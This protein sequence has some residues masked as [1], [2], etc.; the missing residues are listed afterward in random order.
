[1]IK[2][3]NSL[4]GKK[5]EFVPLKSGHVTMYVCGPTVYGPTHVGNARPAVVFDVVRRYLEYSGFKVTYVSNFTDVD[6][7]IINQSRT[8]KIPAAQIAQ[9]YTLQYIKDMSALR[10]RPP[11]IA[12]KVTDHVPQI[13]AFIKGL[14]DKGAAYVVNDGEVF[15]SIRKFK[16]YGKL[17]KK[18]IDDLRVGVRIQPGELKQDPLDFS[19][20]KPQKAP[21]EPAWESPWGKGRPG[22]H[23]ECSA[24]AMH[25]LGET[26][27]IHGGGLDLLHPHH[28][29]EIAQS[30][31]FS[32]KPFV[33]YW[34]HNNL[35][36]IDNEKMSK[37]LGNM[38][39]NFDFIDKYTAET[40]K[41]VLLSGHYRSP[42]DFSV[43]H[44]RDSQAALHRLY[45]TLNKCV[46]LQSAP[47]S[48]SGQPTAEEKEL[49]EMGQGFAAR[50]R[51]AMDDDLNT[52]KVIGCLFDYVRKLNGYLDRKGFRLTAS[53]QQI[54]GQF[55]ECRKLVSGILNVFG[56]EAQGY[57]AL[58]RE[59]VL[60]DRGLE[61][62]AIAQKIAE[63]TEA[64]QQK[65]FARAD[66][67]RQ[68]LLSLGI[69]VMDGPTGT[70]WDIAF[71]EKS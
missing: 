69:Q 68:E 6:D 5:E 18:R 67:I 4:T 48:L 24:M 44:I 63:R 50:F 70:E 45:T 66:A 26:L 49:L 14:V 55:I 28:E 58:L 29:N 34:L 38:F 22:W 2:L 11:N 33:R 53:G 40:L 30:E 8:E 39:Y 42:I 32:G 9:K 64:R 43:Q 10:V 62:A 17:S 36:N 1:M 12:P 35:L 56:E 21:D 13:I 57:L 3:T 46:S 23:I 52:A 65:D 27:D 7:K 61:M 47:S 54:T 20:W 19:L 15:F 25:Y 59:K 51:E 16:D 60:K 71:Q 31:A 37:S 41:F